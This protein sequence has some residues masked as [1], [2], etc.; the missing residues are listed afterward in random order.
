M[1]II[2]MYTH[3]HMH[4]IIIIQ[5]DKCNTSVCPHATGNTLYCIPQV[6]YNKC[7]LSGCTL[8]NTF[9]KG[10]AQGNTFVCPCATRNTFVCPHAMGN[11]FVCPERIDFANIDFGRGA[12]VAPALPPSAVQMSF[13]QGSSESSCGM[14]M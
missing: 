11:T 7:I 13:M 6:A 9:V 12:E 4:I 8:R 1:Y 5:A 3:I 2:K 14:T 10:T